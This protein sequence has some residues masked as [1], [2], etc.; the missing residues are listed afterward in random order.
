[1]KISAAGCCLIDYVYADVPYSTPGFQRFLSRRPG[2]GGIIQGGLVFTEDLSACFGMELQDIL[3]E[4]LG[5]VRADTV[6]LGGPAV[7][8]LVNAA[9]LLHGRNVSC[10]FHACTGND[11][12]GA[13]IRGFLESLPVETRILTDP[14]APSPTTI[15]L[16]DPSCHNGNGERSFLNTIGAAGRI[17]PSDLPLDFFKSDIVLFGGTALTP[18]LH[19]GLYSLLD[20]AKSAGAI[21]VVG[22]VYDFRNEKRDPSAPWPLGVPDAC[23]KIDLLVADAV[24][25]LRLSGAS[26]LQSAALNFIDRG[27]GALVITNG[28]QDMLAWS[29][30]K[31]FSALQLGSYPVSRTVRSI[32]KNDPS[33]LAD[34]TGCGDNFL[35]GLVASLAMQLDEGTAKGQDGGATLRL[36]AASL[37]EALSWG[38]A[39]GGFSCFY[40]GGLYREATAGEKL[41][42][43]RPLAEAYR[44]GSGTVKGGES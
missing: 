4:I 26:D 30:G 37:E 3:G 33:R 43:I 6:N 42:R 44:A 10:R 17:L 11:A 22:T 31:V 12:A 40:A 19:D 7:I 15:V 8:S 29:G 5:S 25:A 38:A 14:E 27:V 35:G 41:Q 13:L 1:V 2:D 20:R 39:S 16:A 21:T 34:T 28:E 23:G 18:A 36:G 9:Q 24:E 32:L